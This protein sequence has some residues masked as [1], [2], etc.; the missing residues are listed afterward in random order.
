MS[1]VDYNLNIFEIIYCKQCNNASKVPVNKAQATSY[2][3]TQSLK[4]SNLINQNL[5]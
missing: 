1:T 4:S 3:V 2:H 5:I